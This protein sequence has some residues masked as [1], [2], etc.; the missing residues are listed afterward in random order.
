MR[1]EVK[2]HAVPHLALSPTGTPASPFRG[3]PRQSQI[4]PLEASRAGSF[5]GAPRALGWL[6]VV[7]A[8][9]TGG[10]IHNIQIDFRP[11]GD[12]WLVVGRVLMIFGLLA[13]L[14]A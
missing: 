5:Y 6:L 11:S 9:E 10:P 2:W 1:P 13:L 14:S 7:A 8:S 12:I 3:P 4:P